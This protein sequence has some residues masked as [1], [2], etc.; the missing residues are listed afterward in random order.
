MPFSSLNKGN[1]LR[2]KNCCR[3]SGDRTTARRG[4]P[5]RGDKPTA[6]EDREGSNTPALYLDGALARIPIPTSN[7]CLGKTATAQAVNF[8]ARDGRNRDRDLVPEHSRAVR[9]GIPGRCPWYV[10]GRACA[11]RLLSLCVPVPHAVSGIL[12]PRERFR[13]RAPNRKQSP[14][15]QEQAWTD[16]PLGLF[17]RRSSLGRSASCLS[18]PGWSRCSQS[19]RSPCQRWT[20]AK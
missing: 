6:Q 12:R 9:Q 14:S 20:A 10:S 2:T 13:G 3:P 4:E 8:I 18:A 11:R 5:S 7:R 16:F 15:Q 19:H 1:L 17:V